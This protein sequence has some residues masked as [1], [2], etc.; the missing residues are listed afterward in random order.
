MVPPEPDD[1][2]ISTGRLEGSATRF[3]VLSALLRQPAGLAGSIL[4][5][6]F[7][8]VALAAPYLA[9]FPPF[10]THVLDALNQPDATY[11]LGSDELGR[12]VL[13]RLIYGARPTI[14]VSF[15]SALG[16]GLIGAAAGIAAGYYRG[17]VDAG[18]MRISDALFA[19]PLIL[20]GICT[21]V[22]LGSGQLQV[23]I[24]LGIGI[25]PAFARLARAEVLREMQRDFIFAARGMGAGD[26]WIVFR[27][28]L[29]NIGTTLVVQMAT[30]ASVSAVLASA[31][32]FLG[33]G[34][35][36]PDPSWGN[37]LQASRLYLAQAPIYALAPGILLTVFVVAINLVAAALTN[38]LNP[39]TRTRILH[40]TH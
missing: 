25:T 14:I 31:L 18:L 39:R 34:T 37:M 27:H 36:P 1:P 6:V 15:L 28:I 3:G 20:I 2:R 17:Y 26:R 24:A 11:L 21:V 40:E 38:A 19:F 29:P 10:E 4:M 35:Q 13:S 22:V 30:A 7:L 5:A 32:D 9:P 12:D 33:L 23:G 16:G 8:L